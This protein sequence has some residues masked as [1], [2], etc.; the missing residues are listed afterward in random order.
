MLRIPK[1]GNPVQLSRLLK[2]LLSHFYSV[3]GRP[4]G[5]KTGR[6]EKQ[7]SPALFPPVISEGKVPTVRVLEGP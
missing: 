6:G 1:L 7:R 3:N 2:L 4:R 5:E